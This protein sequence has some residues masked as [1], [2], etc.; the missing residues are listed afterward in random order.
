MIPTIDLPSGLV[1]AIKERRAVLFLGAG[2]SLECVNDSGKNP[3][4]ALEL[5]DKLCDKFFEGEFKDYD[6]KAIA[7]FAISQHGKANPLIHVNIKSVANRHASNQRV[8]GIPEA[9][10]LY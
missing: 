10:H 5:R 9:A 8:S 1:S 6:L 4:S 2:A 7:D 3:P